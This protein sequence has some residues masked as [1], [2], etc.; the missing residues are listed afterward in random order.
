MSTRDQAGQA[1]VEFA[2]AIP[3]FLLLAF[4]ALELNRAIWQQ[5][6][7]AFAVREGARYA[8]THGSASDDPV[9]P[10]PLSDQPVK[11]AVLRN[12]IG[13]GNVTVTVSWPDGNNDR[14]SRVS[15]EASGTFSA[16][17]L[18]GFFNVTLRGGSTMVIE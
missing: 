3:L 5:N 12:A 7:L 17:G 8:V 11:D 9:G 18:R 2:L 13:S 15:V 1:T 4:G 10:P 16:L 6:T 14:G